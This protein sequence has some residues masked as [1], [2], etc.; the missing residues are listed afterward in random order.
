MYDVFLLLPL[1]LVASLLLY[2]TLAIIWICVK[3]EGDIEREE[4][5][6]IAPQTIHPRRRRRRSG[7][8][9][10]IWISFMDTILQQLSLRWWCLRLRRRYKLCTILNA[11]Y[12]SC[13]VLSIYLAKQPTY[14][15]ASLVLLL[16]LMMITLGW[17]AQASP[18][19]WRWRDEREGDAWVELVERYSTLRMAGGLMDMLPGDGAFVHLPRTVGRLVG[20]VRGRLSAVVC[21]FTKIVSHSWWH[22]LEPSWAVFY[23]R[24]L[25]RYISQIDDWFKVLISSSAVMWI[26][27]NKVG[28]ATG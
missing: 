17:V 1:H 27:T 7:E 23:W 12:Y 22:H 21:C 20:R 13:P 10:T 9:T 4:D 11:V 19:G 28:L 26:D 5:P 16:L 24:Y 15:H 25:G 6:E 2:S 18:C 3:G 14:S 8:P